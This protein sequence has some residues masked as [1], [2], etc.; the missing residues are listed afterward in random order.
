MIQKNLTDKFPWQPIDKREEDL[1]SLDKLYKDVRQYYDSKDYSELLKFIKNFPH[2][3]P[4]NAMLIR[5]Q[6]PG[7]EFVT[8][9]EKWQK[10]N[11]TIK[12]SARPLIILRPFGPV[13][14]VFEINDT[15]GEPLPD[16]ILHPFK[17]EGEINPEV[18][19]NL[20]KNLIKYGIDYDFVEYG[21]NMAG[22]I[23][24]LEE[25]KIKTVDSNG[26]TKDAPIYYCITLNKY[27][28]RQE[29]FSTLVH[30]L[31]HLFCGHVDAINRI[32]NYRN[33]LDFR[34]EEFEAESVAYIVCSRNGIIN[35][36]A[37]YLNCYLDNNKEIPPVSIEAILKAAGLIENMI[38]G[39]VP[40]HKF[41]EA[42]KENQK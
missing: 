16:E 1:K 22:S 13:D 40:Y 15:E 35:N 5:I 27:H 33:H 34:I 38:R 23:T 10:Y 25:K 36:S 32:C 14:F 41:T 29:L 9:L 8:T 21:T 7:S 20:L 3:S 24:K 30:E 4:Y 39:S 37:Q 2:I 26:R 19:I 42:K 17:A 12:P 28:N 11:R 6:K 18:F 31:G